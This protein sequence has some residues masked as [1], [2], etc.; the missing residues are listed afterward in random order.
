ML[1]FVK[2]LLVWPFNAVDNGVPSCL[3]RSTRTVRP[4]VPLFIKT[5]SV[6]QPPFAANWGNT[7]EPEPPIV[8]V[9]VPVVVVIAGTGAEERLVM[10][11]VLKLGPRN[12]RPI[13][14]TG[15]FEEPAD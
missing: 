3:K 2:L 13:T 7:T 10:G 4:L 12:L 14:P 1:M 15:K 9:P 11:I 5:S 6:A 8:A